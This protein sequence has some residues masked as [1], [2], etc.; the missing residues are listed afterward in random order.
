MQRCRARI[1]SLLKNSRC[2]FSL[3]AS[4]VGDFL[5]ILKWN[6]EN[7]SFVGLKKLPLLLYYRIFN[8]YLHNVWF[9]SCQCKGQCQ[10]RRLG[11]PW[12]N[13]KVGNSP[14]FPLVSCCSNRRMEVS[15]S[16]KTLP[17]YVARACVFSPRTACT[18][19]VTSSQLSVNSALIRGS[20]SWGLKAVWMCILHVHDTNRSRHL[21]HS[22]FL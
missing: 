6:S 20:S 14:A 2:N 21:Y 10:S 22:Y 5:H 12:V 11:W 15:E 8:K 7:S 1:A 13:N 9:L 17:S 19:A 3:S 18:L 16:D 4:T